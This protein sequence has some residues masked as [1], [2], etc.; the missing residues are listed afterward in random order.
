MWGPG[1]INSSEWDIRGGERGDDRLSELQERSH[2]RA[3]EWVKDCGFFAHGIVTRSR[4]IESK[5]AVRSELNN[6]TTKVRLSD[7]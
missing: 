5:T 7:F 1:R 3:Q 6:V 2:F 4:Y